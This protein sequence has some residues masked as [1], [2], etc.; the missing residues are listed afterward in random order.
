M[1]P[2]FWR[3]KRVFITGHT[4]F[5]GSWLS[6]WLQNLGAKVFGYALPAPG[7]PSLFLTASVADRMTSILG[8]IRDRSALEDALSNVGPEIVIHL[9]AQPLVRQSYLDPVE[10]YST[11]IMG[12]INLL[13]AVRKSS[14]VRALVN[15]TTDKCYENKEWLLGYREEEPMGGD[16]PYSSSKGCVELISKSYRKSFLSA[17]GIAMATARAG[18][19]IGGGDW[20]IDRLVPD[21]LRSLQMQQPVLI[22]NPNAVRPWQHV[23]DALSGYLLLAERLYK[24]D[25]LDAEGWNFGPNDEDTKS[26]RWIVER[27]CEAWGQESKWELQLGTQ[28]HEANYLKLD[29]S[30]AK[31]RLNWEPRWTLETALINTI[32]WQLAWLGGQDMRNKCIEQINTFCERQ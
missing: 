31:R 5:K 6:L 32:D 3:G 28:Y 17:E 26:V 11:N 19:V 10:T 15:V 18:N 23:L 13:E 21:V 16:D 9:A 27:L 7:V 12:T 14:T 8:D 22:R 2:S 20:A 1:N 30:K 25:Q 4:G 24:Y 29:I